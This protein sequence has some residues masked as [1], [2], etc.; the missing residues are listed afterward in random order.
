MLTF[1]MTPIF[2]IAFKIGNQMPM[3]C[4]F[5]GKGLFN[6]VSTLKASMRISI[7]LFSKANRGPSGNAT[8]NNVI[9][10]NWITFSVFYILKIRIYFKNFIHFW[11]PRAPLPIS[12]YSSNSDKFVQLIKL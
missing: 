6:C 4:A 5:L 7:M 8:T 3:S 1:V 9:K 10:P 2:E 11:P 12:R